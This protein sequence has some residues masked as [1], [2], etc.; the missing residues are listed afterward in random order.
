MYAVP[1]GQG[2]RPT[3]RSRTPAW[4]GRSCVPGGSP[5]S[6]GRAG[7]SSRRR[8]RRRGEIPRDDVALVLFHCLLADNTLKVGF[9]LLSGAGA[10]RSGRARDRQALASCQCSASSS[11]GSWSWPPRPS[12]RPPPTPRSSQGPA[13]TEFYTPPDDPAQGPARHADLAAQA[14]RQGRAQERARPT[15]CCSTSSQAVDGKTVAVSGTVA[16]PKGK[17]PKGGWPVITWAHG[18]VGIADACAPSRD[19]HA[20]QLRQPA[21]QPLAEGG[22]R[23]R[24]HR[25][26]GPRHARRAPVPDRR[27]RGPQHARHGARRAQARTRASARTSSSPATR[28]AATPRCWPARWRRSGRPS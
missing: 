27:L 17:A 12:S 8:S 22:L 14:D 28:R 5:T 11:P 2:A 13:G 10:G 6:R 21:A 18:T 26:R 25:L 19:R 15:R 20:G 9:D 7:S 24:A 1:A 4:A 23:G 16:V 3:R